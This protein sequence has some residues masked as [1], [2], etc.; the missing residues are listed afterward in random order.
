VSHYCRLCGSHRANERFSG[1]GHRTSVCRDCQRL[2]KDERLAIEAGLDLDGFLFSQ[3]HISKKNVERLRE[4]C[5]SPTPGIATLAAIVLQI[6][7]IAP[8]KKKGLRRHRTARWLDSRGTYVR[9]DRSA[10]GVA[11]RRRPLL[12]NQRERVNLVDTQYFEDE[13]DFY[14]CRSTERPA[15]SC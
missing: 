7:T 12:T 1:R 14:P 9:G 11:S 6:A 13:W 2:P 3:S 5:Q 15:Q 10:F 4:L 8:Y